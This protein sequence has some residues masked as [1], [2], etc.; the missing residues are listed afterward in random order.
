V[1]HSVRDRNINSTPSSCF[2]FAPE[3]RNAFCGKR[4]LWAKSGDMVPSR[5]GIAKAIEK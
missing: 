4:V 5:N 3:S 2:D 1:G